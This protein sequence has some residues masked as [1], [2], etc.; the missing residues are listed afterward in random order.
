M[1]RAV[2]F[3]GIVLLLCLQVTLGIRNV[4]ES[5]TEGRSVPMDYDR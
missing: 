1:H 5:T 4:A 2:F 3:K